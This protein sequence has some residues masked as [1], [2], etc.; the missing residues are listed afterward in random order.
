MFEPDHYQLVDFG[1][2]R[3]LER[4]GPYLLDRP[5]PAA[6]GICQT[7]PEIWK[8]ASAR[9]ERGEAER[10]KWKKSSKLPA[11]W[12]IPHESFAFDLKL[13]PFGHVGV[14]AEQAASWDWIERQA[15]RAASPLRVLNLFA[16]TGGSTMA[17]AAAGCEVTHVDAAKNVVA[18]ARSNAANSGLQDAPIRWIAEDAIR[19]VERELRRGNTY[20][21][22]IMDPPSYGHGPKGEVWKIGHN[23]VPLL[24]ACGQLTKSRRAFIL[25]SCHSPGFGPAELEAVLADAIFGHCQG[26]VVARPLSLISV[27]G[28]ELDCG[29]VARWPG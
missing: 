17:A 7:N 14:F 12:S 22:V 4:F 8:T 3:K 16:Y 25:F 11:N 26:G 6:E 28:N 2:G 10:G 1:D 20:D 21:A 19:F 9:F 27:D 13:T 29:A 5:C 23:L 15:A 18:W 24:D